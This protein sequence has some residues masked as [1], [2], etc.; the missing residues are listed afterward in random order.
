MYRIN[1]NLDRFTNHDINLVAGFLRQGKVI[2]YPTDTI[3]GLG[4]LA[5]GHEAID[6]IN[7][8]KKRGQPKPFLV[9]VDSIMTAKSY[10]N[11]TPEH[12]RYLRIIWPG[13]TTVILENKGLLTDA[14][15][16]GEPTLAVRLPKNNFLI[17]ML[18]SLK[19]PII[20]TSLNISGQPYR[21]NLDNLEYYFTGEKPDI[22]VDGGPLPPRKASKIIDIRDLHNIKTLRS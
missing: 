18:S 17:T 10:C 15:T 14:V 19:Q 13:T 5:G 2:I 7:K 22:I 1:I 16:A 9:L 6:R 21:S 8:I 20:S 11:I 12:E 4:C 3:Y